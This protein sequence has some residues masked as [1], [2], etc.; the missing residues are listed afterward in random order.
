MLVYLITADGVFDMF[1]VNK[2]PGFYNQA[3]NFTG[4]NYLFSINIVQ[5]IQCRK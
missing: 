2:A 3:P 1:I 4:E 5:E